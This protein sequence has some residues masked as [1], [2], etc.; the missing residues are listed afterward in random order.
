[1]S[2]DIEL[3]FEFEPYR[4]FPSKQLLLDGANVCPL[5]S[6]GIEILVCL[7]EQA[8]QMVSK[9]ELLERVWPGA[10]VHEANL[11]VNVSALRK[12]LGDGQAGR[13]YIVNLTGQG[14]CFVAP[15]RRLEAVVPRLTRPA[16]SRA[17]HNL[18][19]RISRLHGREPDI[20]AIA[21]QLPMRRCVTVAGPGGI[22]KTT[23]AIAVS[24]RLLPVYDDGVWFVDLSA[25]V[26]GQRIL[27]TVAQ[28][29]GLSLQAGAALSSLLAHLRDKRLL[30]VLDNCEH[31]I[32]AAAKL[33]EGI[34][35]ETRHVSILATSRETLRATGEWVYRLAPLAIPPAGTG[36]TPAEALSFSAVRLFVDCAALSLEGFAIKSAD[37]PLVVAI[38]RGLDGLPLAIE[39]V[40]ARIDILGLQGL[41]SVLEDP[42]LLL[43][44]GRRG[45]FPRQQSLVRTLEWSYRL[46]TPVE[47]TILRRLS[48]FR[49][50]FTLSGAL[51]VAGGDGIEPE[52]VYSGVLTLSAKSLL[53]SD[54]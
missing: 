12:A 9:Q 5:G 27:P 41:A 40:A 42:F 29:L 32:D 2:P 48:V 39:L 18:P 11:R 50:G 43:S 49:G 26:D 8:G 46:L 51:A 21:L 13:R 24:E 38:C 25:I 4:L 36:M 52:D 6:R 30:L 23:V 10:L 28:I 31:V 37:L 1:M 22:G 7:L 47:Q 16:E 3:A 20:E 35:G 33:A 15:V 45:A 14:Y 54:V 44:E 19:A 17:K 53:A 34:L